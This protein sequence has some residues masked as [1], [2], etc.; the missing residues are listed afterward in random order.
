MFWSVTALR[1]HRIW[2]MEATSTETADAD[3]TRRTKS[4]FQLCARMALRLAISERVDILI[5]HLVDMRTANYEF[6][7]A[8]KKVIH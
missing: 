1:M 8:V 4:F 2:I 7:T 3:L 5:L 6:F